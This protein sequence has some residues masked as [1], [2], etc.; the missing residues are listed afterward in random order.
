MPEFKDW[1]CGEVLHEMDGREPIVGIA[2]LS[3]EPGADEEDEA[4]VVC[5][6]Y[7]DKG[8]HLE[9]YPDAEKNARLVAAAPVIFHAL[10]SLI[11]QFRGVA[12]HLG[13]EFSEQMAHAQA[14][15][16]LVLSEEEQ[17]AEL[18]RALADFAGKIQ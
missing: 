15:M 1:C 10:V 16:R 14:A 4:D 11:V 18:E 13:G 6:F 5:T 3:V 2:V 12:D 8:S 17:M 7:E 9:P